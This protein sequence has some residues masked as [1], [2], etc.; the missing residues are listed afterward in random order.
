MK[1]FFVKLWNT[2]KTAFQTKAYLK[3]VS[4]AVALLITGGIVLGVGS[5][6]A[7]PDDP[8]T[9]SNSSSS[10]S[11]SSSSGDGEEEILNYMYLVKVQTV[12]GYGLSGVKVH[13]YD[14]DTEV[15]SLNTNSAGE[16][17]FQENILPQ[18]GTYTVKLT[19]LPVG[20][21]LQ[22][23][24]AV[25]QTA[26]IK[27]MKVAIPLM[28]TGVIKENAPKG[29]KY[30]LG[31]VMYDF[32][33]TLSDGTTTTLS[34]IL[35]EK[36]MVF[37]NFWALRC[38][39]CKQEFPYMNMTYI[40][41]YNEEEN[42][43]YSDKI[44]I[45]A[46]NNE[47]SQSN[48]DAYKNGDAALQFEM[49]NDY[50][51]NAN[52]SQYF[53]LNAIP[54][55]ALI[56]RYGVVASLHTGSLSNVSQFKA[57]FNPYIGEDYTPTIMR[58][59]TVLPGED[60]E[61]SNRITPTVSNPQESDIQAA[62]KNN[63]FTYSWDKGEYSWPW[64]IGEEDGDS[65]IYS[66]NKGVDNSYA[67][68]Y[69]NFTAEAN[70]ALCFDLRMETELFGNGLTGDF[71]Y[72]FI[73][74]A[75]V[76]SKLGR[77]WQWET[78][79]AYV[80]KDF[81]A[82]EH[83]LAIYYM[84]DGTNSS[85]EDVVQIKNIRFESV[86]ALNGSQEVD[87]Y[88][89]RQ[90]AT[91]KNTDEKATTQYQNYVNVVL[92]ETDGYYHVNTKDGPV[93][94]ANVLGSTLFSDYTIYDLA[95]GGYSISD[96]VSLRDEISGMA[97]EANYNYINHGYTP[98]TEQ[99]KNLLSDFVACTT[100]TQ[101]WSGKTHDKEWLELCVYYDHYGDTP[102]HADP[103]LGIT[104]NA[105]LPI[106]VGV[107]DVSVPFEMNPRGFKYKF[108]PTQSGVYN[109]R[110]LGDGDTICFLADETFANKTITGI[111][112]D[113]SSEYLL[114]EFFSTLHSKDDNFNFHYYFEEGKTY[115]MLLAYYDSS[116]YGSYQVQIDYVSATYEYLEYAG[117]TISFSTTEDGVFYVL[118]G[119]EYAK[120]EAD[121]YYH[122]KNAD[123]TL[124]AIL[125]VDTAKAT[126][127]SGGVWSLKDA[128]DGKVDGFNLVIDDVDYTEQLKALCQ[129]GAA[130]TE[131]PGFVAI[132]QEVFKLLNA[133]T[134][135]QDQ[136]VKDE[137]LLMCYYIK[138]LG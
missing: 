1:A 70:K 36:D 56:D 50:T 17:K 21:K 128:A 34:K 102:V 89:I 106:G 113:D 59:D 134:S 126:Y 136:A 40:S 46:I 5:C 53:N 96:G 125:Y 23:E 124:G 64:L 83:E 76:Q 12:D 60:D 121:G 16:A 111:Y 98:V 109:V 135:N 71:F 22:D 7:S 28:P 41:W 123:G 3:W 131:M 13:L 32:S 112:E 29:K 19:D 101:K 103:M 114:G 9:S 86:D 74:G 27:G 77:A 129:K 37:L 75:L 18:L 44:A 43:K 49:L 69:A 94:Y 117:T 67:V 14:G 4:L 55:S 82:G 57:L 91:V 118:D 88:V 51:S 54:V 133:L 119:V 85:G 58:E 97:W 39:P 137:W 95:L 62:L 100:Y 68:L 2:I 72:V 130:N 87:S 110:S 104:C 132:D 65:Y 107:T 122:V 47:D 79:C 10:A 11:S 45:L 61:E 105:A 8:G 92:N 80:F 20:Y 90:A 15:T 30:K 31:D 127:F 6:N 66:S 108:V 93:L 24:S 63:A 33:L 38:A 26:P 99:W 42:L 81:E 78:F 116:V 73:D 48:I 25:Y 84:K 115:Y 35:E 52:V 120:S 138:S